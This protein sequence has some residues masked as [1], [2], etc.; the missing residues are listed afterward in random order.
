MQHLDDP[1]IEYVPL[2]K[3]MQSHQLIDLPMGKYI[4]CGEALIQGEVYQSSCFETR[5]ER[6]DTNSEFLSSCSSY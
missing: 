2:S 3:R 5:I 4:V 6:L 1:V